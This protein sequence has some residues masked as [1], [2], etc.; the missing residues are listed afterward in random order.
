MDSVYFVN[1]APPSFTT[2]STWRLPRAGDAW[3]GL[4]GML[5]ALPAAIAFGVS[6]YSPLGAQ[7]AAAGAL[8][9]V[10]GTIVLG[11]MCAVFGG[12]KGLVTA[13][14]APAAALLSAFTLSFITQGGSPIVALPMLLIVGFI[15]GWLQL[16]LGLLKLGQLIR[17]MPYPVVTGYLSG[18]GIY[19]ILGQ[20]EKLFGL[21]KG[22][23]V[24]DGI[25]QPWHWQ[26]QGVLVGIATILTTSFWV[27]SS[28]GKIT[29][30]HSLQ[31]IPPTV[32]GITMAMLLYGV[33]AY[34]DPA[35]RSNIN[36]PL[37]I[38]PLITE[39][40][41]LWQSLTL[42]WQSLGD[43][44]WSMVEYVFSTGFTLAILLSID[45][46]KTCIIL[47]SL[48][49]SQHDSNR[50]LLSQGRGQHG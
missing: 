18:V 34:V 17:Y 16:I 37:V 41:S 35:L 5:V 29:L 12:T 27:K 7:Y 22:L 38:G 6:I 43:L 21:P 49:K 33:L 19:I 32:A 20:I 14:S 4:V 24:F 45:A 39:E 42:R 13:P 47:D 11:I 44:R 36:N 30:P 23:P 46:L 10:I 25:M 8:A 50:T 48:T 31:K 9:G 28:I 15:T 40:S 3:G 1:N 2:P 26:W